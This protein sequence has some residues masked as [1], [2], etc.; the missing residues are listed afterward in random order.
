VLEWRTHDTRVNRGV[1]ALESSTRWAGRFLPE[2]K[3]LSDTQIHE[4][5][6]EPVTEKSKP[7]TMEGPKSDQIYERRRAFDRLFR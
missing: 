2:H 4:P 5:G 1:D 3:K 7:A 6:D